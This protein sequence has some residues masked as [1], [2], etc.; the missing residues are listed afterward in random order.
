MRGR[1]RTVSVVLARAK[2]GKNETTWRVHVDD[3][4]ENPN[5]AN[6]NQVTVLARFAANFR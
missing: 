4:N 1:A 5:V 3:Q 2:N 6:D